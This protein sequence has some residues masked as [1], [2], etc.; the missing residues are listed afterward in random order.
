MEEKQ[1]TSNEQ[2]KIAHANSGALQ[3]K[4]FYWG[5]IKKGDCH[6]TNLKLVVFADG[7]G[8][9][10]CNVLT[11]HTTFGEDVWRCHFGL[12]TV[13][14]NL[15]FTTPTFNGPAMD[16]GSLYYFS[17]SFIFDSDKYDAI[18]GAWTSASC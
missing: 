18:A 2:E 15:L 6:Q 1:P 9:M 8:F 7:T 3:S 10:A 5:E 13:Y 12:L 4:V 17:G 14:G 16:V 11:N